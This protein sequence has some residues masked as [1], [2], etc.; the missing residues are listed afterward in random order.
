VPAFPWTSG[1]INFSGTWKQAH[2]FG[3]ACPAVYAVCCLIPD[4]DISVSE[5]YSGSFDFDL[6]GGGNPI[7]VAVSFTLSEAP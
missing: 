7:N 3:S 1:P 2:A 6:D 5:S 4:L